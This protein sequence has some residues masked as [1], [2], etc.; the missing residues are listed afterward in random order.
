MFILFLFLCSFYSYSRVHS[1]LIL[2]LFI[3]SFYCHPYSILILFSVIRILFFSPSL[4]DFS[5]FYFS[6]HLNMVKSYDRYEQTKCFGVITSQANVVWMPPSATQSATLMGRALTS[7]LEEILEWD[8]KTGEVLQK[9]RDGITPGALDAST[10]TAPSPVTALCHHAPTNLVAAGHSDGTIKVWDMTSGS[11]VIHFQ[12]HRSAI[13]IVK[14]DS[15]GTR[16]VSGSSDSSIILWDLVGEEGL[17]K[18]KG[19]KGPITGVCFLGDEEQY[20]LSV[21]KDGLVKLWELKSHQCVE[22]HLAHASEC[23]GLA[24]NGAGDMAITSGSKDEVKVWA[25]D[26]EQADGSKVVEKGAFEKQSKARSNEIQFKTVRGSDV[27]Y[28][29]NV[30]RSI[31]V[32]RVRGED[33]VRKGIA[34][35]TKRLREKGYDEEEILN[36]LRSAEISMIITPLVTVRTGA[37][38][39]SCAWIEK[40]ERRAE[41]L[42]ALAN[43]SIECH[44]IAVPEQLKRATD[45]QATRVTAIEHTGHRT[46][47]R[48]MDMSDDARMLCTASNGEMKVWNVRT[49][50]VLRTFILEGGYALCARFLPGHTLVAVGYKNGDLELYDLATSSLVDRV[51]RAH[52][53]AGDEGLAIWTMDLTPDGKTLVTGGNDKSVKFWQFKVESELIP[54]SLER[55]VSRMTFKH[56]QTL[57]LTEDV[58]CV[59][60]SPDSKYLA[61]SLLNNNVQVVFLDTLKLFLTLYG[62]KLPVLSIDILAD[63]KL[64]ITS[65]ADK[66]IKIWGLDF[67][68]CH[69]SIFG[70]QDSVMNVRFIGELHHFF[71]AGKDGLLKYWDG[72]KFECIQKLPAHHGEVWCLCVSADGATMCSTSHDHSIRVW[73]STED[74]VFLEEEREKE[75]DQLYENTLL[76]SL[77]EPANGAADEEQEN[78]DEV[79]NVSHQTMESLKAG[80]KLMEALDIGTADLDATEEYLAQVKQG[81]A[82]I[83]PTPHAILSAFG[84]SGQEYVLSVLC[85]IRAAQLEDAL[86]AMPFSYLLRMLRMIQVWTSKELI[87]A[88]TVNMQLICKVLFFIVR[89]NARELVAQKDPRIKNQLLDVKEQLRGGLLATALQLGVNTQGLRFVRDQWRLAHAT[90]YIDENEQRE[91]VSAPKRSFPTV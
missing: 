44:A 78:T 89:A 48:A 76:D 62:H 49:T 28:V 13:S 26:L 85:K 74:Q 58:L 17:F 87:A 30:D 51:E 37:K 82:A 77:E 32:F 90:E 50:Q 1:I 15:T 18:L 19:H 25:V 8:I 42:V 3:N 11:V 72:D 84:M 68:D 6:S 88:N 27:F 71:S 12:G 10:S 75:I 47:V 21:S 9:L 23:W 64:V 56:T 31:E 38:V 16:L 79:T 22:T 29:Q 73:E 91:R 63:S 61:V 81:K 43:N 65:S 40:G 24:V 69:K 39:K 14:F 66:N 35:R 70:H 41:L 34:R 80:E 57:E 60:V 55:T 45:V 7:G 53:G 5:L 36:N 33:E 54:G 83:R 52:G 4:H 86:L 2:I 59:R 20:I 46:D 67:G